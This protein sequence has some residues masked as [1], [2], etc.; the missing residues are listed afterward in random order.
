VFDA[1]GGDALFAGG[2]FTNA[3]AVNTKR[4]AKWNGAS[5]SSVGNGMTGDG[6]ESITALSV[7]ENV[8]GGALFAGGDFTDA[9]GPVRVHG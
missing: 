1:G 7:L 6:G 9:G 5:W 3:G 8:S 2:N 4:I